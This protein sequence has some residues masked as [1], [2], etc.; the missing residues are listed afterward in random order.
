[1]SAARTPVPWVPVHDH[2]CGWRDCP[3]CGPLIELEI[4]TKHQRMVRKTF[5]K[6]LQGSAWLAEVYGTGAERFPVLAEK[7]KTALVER[8]RRRE[9]IRVKRTLKSDSVK[10]IHDQLRERP[11]RKGVDRDEWCSEVWLEL[12]NPTKL[13]AVRERRTSLNDKVCRAIQRA[14]YRMRQEQ[15]NIT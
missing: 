12:L 10:H 9:E 7:R 5:P 13:C 6:I 3:E 4:E 11:L 8:S 15:R 2:G 1:M 14:E